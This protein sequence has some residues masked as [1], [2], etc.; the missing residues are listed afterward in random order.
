MRE[1]RS[2][3]EQSRAEHCI[4]LQIKAKQSLPLRTIY[5]CAC[6]DVYAAVGVGVAVGVAVFCFRSAVGVG[7]AVYLC[8]YLDTKVM[9]D[10]WAEIDLIVARI[11]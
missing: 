3:A 5:T 4:A 9:N 10:I 7:A 11:K 1:Q 6:A 2:R 8:R